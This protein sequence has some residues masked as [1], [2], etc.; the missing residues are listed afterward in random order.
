[1]KTF[2]IVAALA[3]TT[4]SALTIAPA[5]ASGDATSSGH[6]DWQQAPQHGPRAPLQGPTRRWVPDAPQVA[7]SDCG[8]MKMAS[9][10]A[11]DCMKTMHGVM[12]ASGPAAS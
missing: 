11:A 12:K 5:F 4:L 1:M 6:Y 3:V 7:N 9:A 10:E 2:K 8:V